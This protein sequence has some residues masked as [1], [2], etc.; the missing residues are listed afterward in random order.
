MV[1]VTQMDLEHV[2]VKLDLEVRVVNL[3]CARVATKELVSM[4]HVVV[5]LAGR[6]LHVMFV[7]AQMDVVDMVHALRDIVLVKKDILE[8]IAQISLA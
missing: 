5:S 2:F 3:S 4:A 7:N 6:V 8:M 1:F